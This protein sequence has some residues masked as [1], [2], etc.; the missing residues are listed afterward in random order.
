MA[1]SLVVLNT[2]RYGLEG[3]QLG[4]VVVL[5]TP[6]PAPTQTGKRARQET[7][8]NLSVAWIGSAAAADI[9]L[10]CFHFAFRSEVLGRSTQTQTRNLPQP[11]MDPLLSC[12]HYAFRVHG[13]G[14]LLRA[15]Q[16]DPC[17]IQ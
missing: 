12:F 9:L 5:L 6:A 3:T 8:H 15:K 1:I 2:Q 13:A 7:R 4:S 14:L 16:W 11:V 10:S 17:W